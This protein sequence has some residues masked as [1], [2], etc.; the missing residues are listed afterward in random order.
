[1]WKILVYFSAP[2]FRLVPLFVCSGN[3]A[4]PGWTQI[5]VKTT[6]LPS[7]PRCRQFFKQLQKIALRLEA[8]SPKVCDML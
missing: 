6:P 5:V 7:W 4:G 1:M 2:H 3:G 8:S